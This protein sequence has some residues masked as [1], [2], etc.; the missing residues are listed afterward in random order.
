M[1]T[2]AT[3]ADTVKHT[4]E[5]QLHGARVEIDSL[6]GA[7]KVSGFIVWDGFRGME[8]IDRQRQVRRILHEALRR[9]AQRVSTILTYSPGEFELMG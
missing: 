8:Q 7:Q 4:L 9:D 3:I 5:Q 2:I 6:P 1:A